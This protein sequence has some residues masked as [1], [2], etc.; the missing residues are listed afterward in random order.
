[1]LLHAGST[2][3]F[4]TADDKVRAVITLMM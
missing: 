1:M 4:A 2:L 3:L